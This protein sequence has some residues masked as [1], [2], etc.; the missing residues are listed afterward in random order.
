M[1]S[2]VALTCAA[3]AA[4]AALAACSGSGGRA[5]SADTPTTARAVDTQEVERLLIAT[6]K[7]ASP[8]FDVRDAS[9]PAR[10]VVSEGATFECTVVVEGVIAPYTITLKDVNGRKKTGGYDLRPSKAILSVPKIVDFVKS[11]ATD[12]NARV[13]CGPD[14]VKVLD[15]G[16]TFDCKLTDAAGDHTVTL[17]VDDVSGKVTL[18]GAT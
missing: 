15:P 1:P 9:C 4:A 3:V 6:Q 10:V 18:L 17:R 16:A 13:D 14:R 7:R 5:K 8:D 12:P 11:S 2:G